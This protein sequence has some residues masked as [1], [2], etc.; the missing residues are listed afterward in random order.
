MIK[1]ITYHIKNTENKFIKAELGYQLGGENVW[2]YNK[3]RRGYYAYIRRVK[4]E[5]GFESFMLADGRKFLLK[6]VTRKTKKAEAEAE[7]KFDEIHMD[8]IKRVYPDVE[9]DVEGVM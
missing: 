1:T 9:L 7:A 3:E 4:R 2:T 6:E 8:L 5:R